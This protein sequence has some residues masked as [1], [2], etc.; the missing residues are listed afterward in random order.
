MTRW[1]VVLILWPFTALADWFNQDRF[2]QLGNVISVSADDVL[3]IRIDPDHTSEVVGTLA[4]DARD[5]EIVAEDES[6][7]WGLLNS[8][9]GSGW[10]RLSFIEIP[11]Q[12]RWHEFATPMTCFGTEP[13]WDFTINLG[14]TEAIYT[15]YDSQDYP[16][17]IDWTSGIAARPHGTIGMGSSDPANGFS[18]V[19][20]NQM[21]HDGMSDRENALRIRLFIHDNGESYG[22][23]GCCGLS[24]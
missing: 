18:A 5:I 9:E 17:P 19:I 16:F 2:P 12:P 21:C 24:P 7:K 11:E 6:G 20:E 1:V 22:L 8:G 23:D 14:A 15:D 4:P 13:F 3:N 10:V